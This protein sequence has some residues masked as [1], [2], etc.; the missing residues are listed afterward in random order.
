MQVEHNVPVG[1]LQSFPSVNAENLVPHRDPRLQINGLVN[2]REEDQEEPPIKVCLDHGR[3][4]YYTTHNGA[5]YPFP[6][7]QVCLRELY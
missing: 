7:D 3:F 2:R 1:T 5:V 6:I 4:Y